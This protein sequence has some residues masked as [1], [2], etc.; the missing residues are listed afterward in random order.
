MIQ[1]VSHNYG[2]EGVGYSLQGGRPENQ[3]DMGY[4]ETPLGFLIVV[5]D[6]MGGGPGGKTASYIVK[7]TI[8]ET[9]SNCSEQTLP[10]DALKLAVNKASETM[11]QAMEQRLELRGMGSTLVA[12]L[13]TNEKAVIAH[14]G[15]SR[16]YKIRSNKVLY[17]SK[18]HSLVGELVET[19]AITEEQARLSP[20]SNVITRALGSTSNHVAEIEEIPYKAGDRFVICTDGVWG[21]MP[22]QDLLMRLTSNQ[23]IPT[24]V[25][26]LSEEIDKIGI[27]NGG[28]YDNHTLAVIEVS[29]N[30]KLDEPMNKFTKALLCIGGF[31]LG[32]SLL[33]NVIA[34]THTDSEQE[35]NLLLRI[36][37]LEK[38]NNTLSAQL[39]DVQDNYRVQKEVYDEYVSNLSGKEKESAAYVKKLAGECDSMRHRIDSLT[40]IIGDLRN[41]EKQEN[42][43]R[44]KTAEEKK[45]AVGQ[46]VKATTPKDMLESAI[47][48]LTKL[49]NKKSKDYKEVAQL[50]KETVTSVREILHQFNRATND[51]YSHVTQPVIK[52]LTEDFHERTDTQ[53]LPDGSG[54]ALSKTIRDKLILQIEGLEKLKKKLENTK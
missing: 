50:E 5:C 7:N 35:K 48:K 44:G 15:D 45:T 4:L 52:Q 6:G 54:C 3:D 18:D 2:I 24:L 37:S 19:G 31:A 49:K 28:S 29:R 22:H 14:L 30:S 47:S 1:I 34:F 11:E 36:D 16:C 38:D 9:I 8:L 51:K 12:L 33:F 21:I 23:D 32:V 10:A 53:P 43:K 13:I 39:V 20:Q 46:T 25:R 26:N 27:S 41:A 17:R 40:K 42:E